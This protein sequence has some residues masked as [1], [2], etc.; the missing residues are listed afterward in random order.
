MS[1]VVRTGGLKGFGGLCFSSYS[2]PAFGILFPRHRQ[3]LTQRPLA[4]F[5]GRAI[6]MQQFAS[7]PAEPGQVRMFPGPYER[8]ERLC[9]HGQ[10]VRVPPGRQ[11]AVGQLLQVERA[12]IPPLAADPER[13]AAVLGADKQK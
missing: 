6:G 3:R 10:S 13:I 2:F 4:R 5:V 9:H 7:K 8:V 12:G 1:M 11:Q